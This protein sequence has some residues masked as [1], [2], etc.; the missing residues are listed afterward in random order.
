MLDVGRRQMPK[1][2]ADDHK[3]DDG[4]QQRDEQR[5]DSFSLSR[6]TFEVF[7]RPR[8]VSTMI[9]TR[10]ASTGMSPHPIHWNSLNDLTPA[11]SPPK[12]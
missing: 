9:T 12:R 7:I 10:T 5:A 8:R 11:T 4:V 3:A 2:R 1:D 6:G